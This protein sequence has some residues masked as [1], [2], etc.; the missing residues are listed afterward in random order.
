MTRMRRYEALIIVKAVGTEQDV[1]H[2]VAKLEEP[3][4]KVGGRIESAQGWG[5][6]RFAFRIGRQTEGHYQLLRFSV[7][8]E[9]VDELKRL[10]RLNESVI[11]F[12]VLTQDEA[13]TGAPA[14]ARQA[15]LHSRPEQ[16]VSRTG[17]EQ[18]LHQS[19]TA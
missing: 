10:F 7:P 6:R 9:V 11:R 12:I 15:G 4:R 8:T 5:R 19:E 13:G 2:A 3:I 16:A 14:A 1:A 17:A 18:A